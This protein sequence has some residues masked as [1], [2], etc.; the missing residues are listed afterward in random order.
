VVA[1][2]CWWRAAAARSWWRPNDGMRRPGGGL[3]MA[4]VTS[5]EVRWRSATAAGQWARDVKFDFFLIPFPIFAE[6]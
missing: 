2:G 4:V 1:T 6:S 3:V 5:M